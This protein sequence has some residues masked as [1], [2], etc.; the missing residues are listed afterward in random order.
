MLLLLV[1]LWALVPAQAA[2]RLGADAEQCVQWPVPAPL[3]PRQAKAVLASQDLG[4]LT[5]L[6][7]SGDYSRGNTAAR[8]QIAQHFYQSH[9]DHF[10]TLIVFSSFE[11]D[12]GG[13]TAVYHPVRNDVSGIG[14]ESFDFASDYGSAGRLSGIVD[15]AALSRYALN[16]RDRAYTQT[17]GV[18]AHELQH[19]FAAKVRYQPA[20][21]SVSTDL[22]GEGG[23]HW[24]YFLDTDASLMYGSDWQVSPQ[25]FESVQVRH[26]FSPLDL[27]LAGLAAA[28]EVPPLKLI[29][30]GAG[31]AT[32]LP[33][34]GARTTGSQE[35]I[36]IGQIIAAEGPR[37]PDTAVAP[38][39][40][41][42]ALLV[43][44]RPGQT[45]PAEQLLQLEQ[46]RIHIAQFYQAATLGRATL[47]VGNQRSP[48]TSIAAPRYV[49]PVVTDPAAQM[50]GAN[51][52]AV[53]LRTRQ[54][55]DGRFADLPSTALRDT[56]L[57]LRALTFWQPTH[58]GNVLARQW[59]AAQS[60]ASD[61]GRR[62]QSYGLGSDPQVPALWLSAQTEEG[63][64][65]L[66]AGWSTSI[67]DTLIATASLQQLGQADRAQRALLHLAGFQDA[68]GGMGWIEQGVA[69]ESVVARFAD[70]YAQSGLPGTADQLLRSRSWLEA[71][72]RGDG[73]FGSP[74]STLHDSVMVLASAARLG[75]STTRRA[76]LKDFVLLRSSGSL[77]SVQS[78]GMLAMT[79][80]A[81][82]LEQGGNLAIEGP[83][84]VLPA[85]P[86]DGQPV[87]LAVRVRNTGSDPV[88]ASVLRWFE[89]EP[90]AG[91]V[92]FGDDVQVPTLPPGGS[93]R[94]EQV[95]ESRGRPGAHPFWVQLDA[96][97][98]VL[99][100]REDDNLAQV[101]VVVAPAPAG[102][103][104]ALV[105]AETTLD[106][107]RL[108]T[109]PATVR[110]RGILRNLGAT[111]ASQARLELAIVTTAGPSVVASALLD[112]A[113]RGETPFDLSYVSTQ[114][115]PL[116]FSLRVDPDE[117]WTEA[118][119]SNNSVSLRLEFGSTL[120]L[121]IAAADLLLTPAQPA[122]GTLA[123]LRVQLHNRGTQNAQGVRL[124]VDSEVGSTTTTLLD[125]QLS[126]PAAGTASRE[127]PWRP[128][129]A[130]STRLRVRLDPDNSIAE[131]DETN[132]S[133][134][135]VV[136]VLPATGI[137]LFALPGSLQLTPV[138]PLEGQPLA[139][140]A[141][142]R[143]LGADAAP[144]FAVHLYSGT[145]GSGGSLLAQT[146]VPGLAANAE[147]EVQLA[148]ADLP[149][150]GAHVLHLL[151]DATGLVDERD[152]TD[153]LLVQDV[154]VRALPD[155]ALGSG[156][157]RLEPVQP[158]AGQPLTA[159]LRIENLGEQPAT[160]VRA[161]LLLGLPEDGSVV[162]PESVVTSIAA[163]AGVDL[164]WTFTLPDPAPVSVLSAIVD[165][166]GTVRET[167]EDNNRV[168]VSF[169][170]QDGAFFASPVWFS[171]DGDGVQDQTQLV[172]R[173]AS[174]SSHRVEIRDGS[175]RLVRTWSGG[176]G[177]PLVWSWDGRD[178][179]GRVLPDGRYEAQAVA[180]TSTP[181]TAPLG[182]VMVILDTNRSS[183]LAALGTAFA[184]VQPLRGLVPDVPIVEPS[185]LYAVGP[186]TI[187]NGVRVASLT[188]YDVVAGGAPRA[189]IADAL[190][191]QLAL[192]AGLD[193]LELV[194][195]RYARNGSDALLAVEE[196]GSLTAPRASLWSVSRLDVSPPQRLASLPTGSIVLGELAD[197]RIVIGQ[198]DGNGAHLV[199]RSNGS[200]TPYRGFAVPAGQSVRVTDSGLLFFNLQPRLFVPADPVLPE[201]PLAGN[202]E[203]NPFFNGRSSLAGLNPAATHLLQRRRDPVSGEGR[204]E[205]IR[206][207]GGQTQVLAQ[208]PM[209][210]LQASFDVLP[211]FDEYSLDAV[212]L[213]DAQLLVL[214][215]RLMRVLWFG[216]DGVLRAQQDLGGFRREEGYAIPT[217]FG[218]MVDRVFPGGNGLL[219]A[220]RDPWDGLVRLTAGESVFVCAT[221]GGACYQNNASGAEFTHGI[222]DRFVLGIGQ[223]PRAEAGWALLPMAGI[224]DRLRYPAGEAFNF[225]ALAPDQPFRYFD[226]G[227]VLTRS[228]YLIRTE[229]RVT[230][231]DVQ[232]LWG[233]E[234]H[235]RTS[236]NGALSSLANLTALLR[237]QSLGRSI[238]LSGTI[239]DAALAAWELSWRRE[240]STEAWQSIAAPQSEAV[241]DDFLLD[242]VPPGAGSWRIRLTA[243]DRAGNQRVSYAFADTSGAPPAIGDVQLSSRWL[244]PNGDGQGET[245][246][247]RL[248]VDA[249][250]SADV[251]VRSLDSGAIVRR[252][253]PV[254]GAGD[255]GL[256]TL[257][258]DGRSDAG[259]L[260]PDGPYQVE[261]APGFALPLEIDTQAPVGGI[262]WWRPLPLWQPN[263]LHNSG[264]GVF[265]STS[266]RETARRQ[267]DSMPVAGSGDWSESIDVRSDCA[268]K[269]AASRALAHRWRARLTDAA[270]NATTL[271]MP[272]VEA[273]L[274]LHNP[275]RDSRPEVVL[276]GDPL[277][278]LFVDLSP[279][280]SGLRLELAPNNAP[281]QWRFQ[282]RVS[283]ARSELT[284]DA[285]GSW[286]W[287]GH[288]VV[289]PLDLRAEAPG[290]WLRV[291]GV[292]ERSNASELP[293]NAL[294]LQ[295]GVFEPAG[296]EEPEL[297]RC[298]AVLR[299]PI[300][301]RPWRQ[302]QLSIQPVGG[303][304]GTVI[305]PSRFHQDRQRWE[306]DAAVPTGNW[307]LQA[308]LVD[309]DGV[310]RRTVVLETGCS[311][312]AVLAEKVELTAASVRLSDACDAPADYRIQ[313]RV[314][315]TSAS[316]PAS[317]AR[318]Y[319]L[320]LANP[321]T[322]ASETLLDVQ[323]AAHTALPTVERQLNV[324]GWPAGMVRLQ[325]QIGT[326]IVPLQFELP[327]GHAPAPYFQA[328]A[329]GS[330]QCGRAFPAQLGDGNTLTPQL[331]A[332]EW[333]QGAAPSEWVASGAPS[334]GRGA[335]I[336]LTPRGALPH[337]PTSVRF[338]AASQDGA[339]ACAVRLFEIDAQA[340]AVR[341][342][343]A[344][345]ILPATNGKLGLSSAGLEEFRGL[346]VPLL[347]LEPLQWR[348]T[349]APALRQDPLVPTG[350]RT[351]L[352]PVA[353]ADGEYRFS[354]DGRL[355][356]SFVPDGDYVLRI[357]AR[358]DCAHLKNFDHAVV[359][360]STPPQIDLQSPPAGALI[361]SAILE[362]R[363]TVVD[364]N[365]RV[366][367]TEIAALA[368]PDQWT[369]LPPGGSPG[370]LARWV[371]GNASGPHRLRLTA[372][373]PLGN[374]RTLL[375]ELNLAA[376]ARLL[377][378]AEVLP[379]WFSPNGDGVADTTRIEI[380][381]AQSA[382]L[383]LKAMRG[384]TLLRTLDA[385]TDLQP[386]GVR[387]YVWDGR[388]GAGALVADGEVRLQLR[389]TS[390]DGSITEQQELVLAID[391][392]A[393]QLSDRVPA[394]ADLNCAQVVSHSIADPHF[395]RYSG[396]LRAADQRLLREVISEQPGPMVFDTLAAFGDAGTG[397]LHLDVVAEDLA[398]NRLQ[399]A[400]PLRLDCELPT[401]E[402]TAPAVDAVLPRR[403]GDPQP[404]AGRALDAQLE[405]W[406][407]EIGSAPAGDA[408]TLIQQGSTPVDGATL[409][410]WQVNAP[411]GAHWLRLQ[412]RDRA[413]N[414]ASA[415][416]GIQV[417]GTPPVAAIASPPDAAT[418]T[419]AL[420]VTGSASDDHLTRYAL[421]LARSAAGP[422]ADAHVGTTAVQSGLLGELPVPGEGEFFLRLQV[423]D[424]AGFTTV[425]AA[426]R[427]RIDAAPP[428][429]PAT[430]TA[431]AEQNRD[432][433]LGWSEVTVADLAGYRIQRDGQAIGGAL[434]Q[435]TEFL[436]AH[437][438]EGLLSYRVYA[439]DTAGNVGE[440]S[441]LAS[442]AID[443]TPPRVRLLS[444]L[445]DSRERG[446]V[447]V[448]GSVAAD[449][450]LA[451]YSLE[452][453]PLVPPGSAIELRRS[454]LPVIAGELG[455]LDSSGISVETQGV[456]RLL[457]NDRLGN[458]ASASVAVTIDNQ[459]PA[460]PTGLTPTA[461]A[462]DVRLQWNANAETDLLGYLLYRNGVPVNAGGQV[463]GDLRALALRNNEHLDRQVPDGAQSWRV[464]AIDRA[465]NISPPSV[466]VSLTVEHG[467]PH[468]TFVIPASG[469]AF[470][471][472]A[473]FVAVCDDEDVAA[474][475]FAWRPAG[476]T[477]SWNQLATIEAP[478]WRVRWTPTAA[479]PLGEYDVRALA[480]DTGGR[481]DPVPERR[482]V[483][484]ADLTPPPVPEA[485]TALADGA[486]V[487]LSWPAVA[488]ADLA[489]Y[490]LLR[491]APN[492]ALQ[493]LTP[494]P[495]TATT[496]LDSNLLDGRWVY[497]L[498]AVDQRGN[499]SASV[500]DEAQLFS[501]QLE[502]PFTPVAQAHVTLRG[503]SAVAGEVL[504]QRSPAFDAPPA[505]T[506]TAPEGGFEVPVLPL[507]E[508]SNI[509]EVR[510]RSVTGD[511][512]R[513]AV[514]HLDRGDVPP[515]PT[516]L[517][518]QL[519]ADQ[520]LLDWDPAA[521]PNLLGYTVRDRGE[522]IPASAPL[523]SPVTLSGSCCD[524]GA[525]HDGD[526]QTYWYSNY[527]AQSVL[528]W[529]WTQSALV[530]AL[531][532]DWG[533]PELRARS[534]RLSGWS[535]HHWVS[536]LEVT[537]VAEAAGTLLRLPAAYRTDALR[538]ELV[539]MLSYVHVAESQIRV[540]PLLSADSVALPATDGLHRFQVSA[541]NWY[542]MQSPWSTP[543]VELPVGD[544]DPPPA[545]TL[546]GVVE[547]SSARLSWTGA[548]ADVAQWL[549]SRDGEVIAAIASTEAPAHVDG[550][551]RNGRYRYQ[552]EAVDAAGN[553]SAASNTVELDIAATGPAVPRLDSVRPLNTGRALELRWTAGSEGAAVT[554]F[555]I[556]NSTTADG[557]FA[558]RFQAPPETREFVDDEV[559]NGQTR[560]YRLRALDAQGN[561]SAWS[562]VLSGTAGDSIAPAAP[563]LSLPTLA[564]Q[565]L[566]WDVRQVAVCGRAEPG[567]LVQV[568]HNTQ[569]VGD[570]LVAL[571]ADR[572]RVLQTGETTALLLS[573]LA[574]QGN[575]F[576][577]VYD[578][579]NGVRRAE[580]R[581][582]EEPVPAATQALQPAPR[583]P[584]FARRGDLVWG[585]HP[586]TG[587]LLEYVMG[588]GT[589][590]AG[591]PVTGTESLSNIEAL[592]L[593]AAATTAVIAAT[594]SG[595]RGLWLFDRASGQLSLLTAAEPDALLLEQ[596]ALSG[597]ATLLLLPGRD[598]RLRLRALP[599]GIDTL[600][601]A[602]LDPASPV[603]ARLAPDQR[604]V[605]W[606][607]TGD[608]G[609]SELWL[610]RLAAPAAQRLQSFP[611]SPNT[612]LY[613]ADG[614]EVGVFAQDAL[615]RY[616]TS[617]AANAQIGSS[618]LST[619]FRTPLGLEA[620]A[621]ARLLVRL[622]P[623]QSDAISVFDLAGSFCLR[624]VPTIVG[625]NSYTATAS[626]PGEAGAV[627]PA[628]AAAIIDVPGAGLPDLAVTGTDLR[629]SP[630]AAV[631]GDAVLAFVT[632]RNSGQGVANNPT[633]RVRWSSPAGIVQTLPAVLPGSIAAGS[634]ASIGIDL[635]RPTLLGAWRLQ[636]DAD[637]TGL[638][639]EANESNNSASASLAV[640]SNALPALE[641]TLA[642]S[643]LGPGAVLQG[644]V[645]FVAPAAFQGRVRV[646]VRDPA[647][648]L[649]A[650]VLDAHTGA[651]AAAQ[652]W[653][654]AFQWLPQV[655]AG[656]YRVQAQLLSVAGA[657]LDERNLSV[658]L[659]TQRQL[660]LSVRS[661][662]TS[663]AASETANLLLSLHFQS[664]NALL[665]QS[666][667]RLDAR[668][669]SG[670]PAFTYERAL[671]TLT[672]GARLEQTVP[673]ALLSAAPG[674]Y[675]IELTLSAADGF[676]QQASTS[677]MVLPAQPVAGVAGLLRLLPSASL[678]TG[679][680]ATLE[681]TL[682][683]TG[684]A[685][686][687]G[688]TARV[689]LLA[690]PA[691]TEIA[692][693]SQVLS[694]SAQQAQARSL[695]V[696]AAQI[697]VGDYL[698]VLEA[699]L[700]EDPADSWR[701]LAQASLRVVDGMAPRITIER[702]VAASFQ[703]R[704]TPIRATI[705]DDESG[706]DRAE[707]R[708]DSGAW[709]AIGLV[710]E[711][712]YGRTEPGLAEGAHTVEMRAWDRQGNLSQTAILAFEVDAQPPVIAVQG[713]SDGLQ[714]RDPLTPLI[715]V[716]D[717]HLAES[718]ITLDGLA[719]VSGTLVS[720]EG[721]HV[722]SVRASDLAGNSS[723]RTLIF[724]IDRSAP[725]VSFLDPAEGSQHA[726]DTV[727]VS[728]RSEAGARIA[729]QAQ[730]WGGEGL[731]DENGQ[732][733]F[734]AVP[735]LPGANTLQAQATDTA[736]NTGPSATLSLFRLE[737]TAS[738]L[739]DVRAQAAE[740]PLGTALQVAVRIENQGTQPRT[741]TFVLQ[742][743]PPTGSAA[744]YAS[745]F[746]HSFAVNE[747]HQ[748]TLVVPTTGYGLGNHALVLSLQDPA[749]PPQQLGNNAV[750][751]VDAEAPQLSLLSPPA[752]VAAALDIRARAQDALSTLA[753]VRARLDGGAWLSLPAD[754]AAPQEFVLTQVPVS[755][756]P[757]QMD[758]EALDS[759][760]NRASVS[761]T[762]LSDQ[763]AP[764]LTVSGVSDGQLGNQ[765]VTPVFSASD[766]HPGSVQATLDGQSF[767]SGTEVGTD[768]L[769]TLLVT[770]T[771]AV[772]NSSQR[773]LQFTIDRTP[774]GLTI[775]QPADGAVILMP[776]V[777]VTGQTEPL[778]TVLLLRGGDQ[779]T[780][781]ADAAGVFTVPAVNLQPG[782]N[783]LSARAT[784]R[785]GNIGLPRTVQVEY[786]LNAGVTLE[787]TL[788]AN[789]PHPHGT[790]L[791][792]QV[793]VRNTGSQPAQNLPLRLDARRLGQT[794]LLDRHERLQ[795]LAVG[796]SQ[797][798]IHT[799]TSTA[800]WPWAQIEIRLEAQYTL[801]DG[802]QV[803]SP[804]ATTLVQLRDTVAPTL[805][806]LAPVA[807]SWHA[808]TV[809][810]R[811][812]ASDALSG[813][814]QVQARLGEGGP[815]TLKSVGADQYEG[816]LST[817]AVADGVVLLHLSASDLDGNTSTLTPRP[818]QIDRLAP[819][820]QILDVADGQW[821]RD[822]VLPRI[823]VTDVNPTSTE[824]TL[825]GQIYTPG[826]PIN[827]EGAHLLRVRATD[828]AGNTGQTEVRFTIDRTAPSI[829]L[830]HPL[831]GA[832]LL[833]TQVQLIGST[834]A[835]AR[836]SASVLGI[837]QQTLADAQG[838]FSFNVQL[839]RGPN[840]I[841][842]TAADALGNTSAPLQLTVLVIADPVIA[843]AGAIDN[844]PATLAHGQ[845]LDFQTRVRNIGN[846]HLTAVPLFLRVQTVTAPV[847]EIGQQSWLL[848]LEVNAQSQRAQHFKTAAWPV[849]QLRLIL[850]AELSDAGRSS[851][852]TRRTVLASQDLLLEDRTAPTLAWLVPGAIGQALRR[853]QAIE[854]SASD[855]QSGLDVVEV[856]FDQGALWL[857]MAPAEPKLGR[858]I[859]ALGDLA[860]GTHQVE[861]RARDR[862]GNTE[863]LPVR[864]FNL[865]RVLPL[866]LLEPA[867]GATTAAALLDLHALS[868]PLARV[869]L[870]RQ[871]QLLREV[872]A[873]ASGRVVLA[874]VPLA[875]G[876]NSF[877]V[878]AFASDGAS[879]AA[880]EWRIVRR[881]PPQVPVAVLAPGGRL[882][883]L[884]LIA[885]IG[886]GSGLTALRRAGGAP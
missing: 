483:R 461:V 714:T 199:D 296:L 258:F 6:E 692:V 722:L 191:A 163:G 532:L 189:R 635:G 678:G 624:Q 798:F 360:D 882:L 620:A 622:D 248:R 211:A 740:V 123:Q 87:T 397:E 545:P 592:R 529:R 201:V 220:T 365:G 527:D 842:L 772:G 872:V 525:A 372:S 847:Q 551:L 717:A 270:G 870:R 477:Q 506:S 549:L 164:S 507:A 370:V 8:Q 298:T 875:F 73:G 351:A 118:D 800:S 565:S 674:G 778:A 80:Q 238:R 396:Q 444:P 223:A 490:E 464:Y 552:L 367:K 332:L 616:T 831:P 583:Q 618:D 162:P 36:D 79:L 792:I 817:A 119:E 687:T 748:R 715:S 165:P 824:A 526:P 634:S 836:L 58:P 675:T 252:F 378:G 175:G 23:V 158:I 628:S 788:G 857:P 626:D 302:V 640:T 535:G 422:W 39:A 484:Y 501:V 255:L 850:E 561:A 71:R 488:A 451:Q 883:L 467:P 403:A 441:P 773:S 429:A 830:I 331:F 374:E 617:G 524:P 129:A 730:G 631:S 655:S 325:A 317:V 59:L 854:V 102:V 90:G 886:I 11:F 3:P 868:E 637:P 837:T 479:I 415:I 563:V 681:W 590:L 345:S 337:G 664:G 867:P 29:R 124:L 293:S 276:P 474:V 880:L 747:V 860:A 649:V 466:T 65:G 648:V 2:P 142:L 846:T 101:E 732:V 693:D 496:Y 449:D 52:L 265:V 83:V 680:A 804:V 594:R 511:R 452:F 487:R 608:A 203:T 711:G 751:L 149:L 542:G 338:R 202:Q 208:G 762:V 839:A 808:Q 603:A 858:W 660:S 577:A 159:H 629:F 10:D 408:W 770:A 766:P 596:L 540:Q 818:L 743:L 784:D 55:G 193:R 446:E 813:L 654:S 815:V 627:S 427:L 724:H 852:G 130:G 297:G 690:S 382:R 437:A 781:Q 392:V 504:L 723:Q 363:G 394:S 697:S 63:G 790:P 226:S 94:T 210:R 243:R 91:G 364:A 145:P 465:G 782:A 4:N 38:R 285:L 354:W 644:H 86:Y 672:P 194:Q 469:H 652:P 642:T 758:V 330:R 656:S 877:R 825:D 404:I 383:D 389:L 263:C 377:G 471:Q 334:T 677:L 734:P 514:L 423:E 107:N 157:L 419:S 424:G 410:T 310:Q 5:V 476:S 786:R 579:P 731:A 564:T 43:L 16:P 803:W 794:A 662:R 721:S 684:T 272:P 689:R 292:G 820:V 807:G 708:I 745:E 430:L 738:W 531:Q 495:L 362:L 712:R 602:T 478:P 267:L 137:N 264:P 21:G 557:P 301:P 753:S 205:L 739:G 805:A 327:P 7:F 559:A 767:V 720:A 282:S 657:T 139:V 242:W 569:P 283:G 399:Q 517:Q 641:L 775:Q 710:G 120:D 643:V 838:E 473:E 523:D 60:P 481:V 425:T 530:T 300:L 340:D 161:R 610:R 393:P 536:L 356:G 89:G 74:Q 284:E 595:E 195:L 647:G 126:L 144:P 560:W 806:L 707:L 709:T 381:V 500:E 865:L 313:L 136:D 539:S 448:L 156:A 217:S 290:S 809:L 456:F 567:S 671:G 24:S 46:L 814:Q 117:R 277:E 341:R 796:A 18:L 66:R 812:S 222:S 388:D 665:N 768:G 241:I 787:A 606:L 78:V 266:P 48:S 863:A 881:G 231:G 492:G 699:R 771:D 262:D 287:L 458:S 843:L 848:D 435:G 510:V 190:W 598:G 582:L 601:T 519:A 547:G 520:M 187:A 416:R 873:D 503:R 645:R 268:F 122:A 615:L 112:V 97:G 663:Y 278:R 51:A 460:A 556:Q 311:E 148:V 368:T 696:P 783:T 180:L 874:Q 247:L 402:L 588:A 105:A 704:P 700:P 166:A 320:R 611:T 371:R 625:R 197:G 462:L 26:R 151:V 407:L 216:A 150:R 335:S 755:E 111:P 261:V 604:S 515:A 350:P 342:D 630:G 521:I 668:S 822:P 869:T 81:L 597:D 533:A 295:I 358:D 401:A 253:L 727:P 355:G 726:T 17:L 581:S 75:L 447:I 666:R 305:D 516:G 306:F 135:I 114:A 57:A 387:A 614:Q 64:Y 31:Q 224:G 68:Q 702:P 115:V 502:V 19:R 230:Q 127:I 802:S 233:G 279:G 827:A 15:M 237:A 206:L 659:L 27:Y 633:L 667:L 459:A 225:D 841:V 776:S 670:T 719:F 811:A 658:Q 409:A 482:S 178:S 104:L 398:G 801:P 508:G 763:S 757:H 538:L 54:Q 196:A 344:S 512:S 361:D 41:Q 550:G 513:A 153:N 568:L 698:G 324:N 571:A 688:V 188:E 294:T 828:L 141:R 321:L 346:S 742:V 691:L 182:P 213:D 152:E 605:S 333:G 343:G 440:G 319:Q 67:A 9:P 138:Q 632:V 876:D 728:L 541:W 623:F 169:S 505:G 260:L 192:A 450:D 433:R 543:V 468:A 749:G 28:S 746:T 82:A 329:A 214:D 49:I 412:V 580:L 366:L 326:A 352:G 823:V 369:T 791:P 718:S 405:Q 376:P 834:E 486:E 575:S 239:S 128:T 184:R 308:S 20:G 844:A 780:V 470:E 209:V 574:P 92:G 453:Q 835:A 673:W 607:Q 53:V 789:T 312:P 218:R 386:A 713:V 271:V 418:V 421:Q 98:Q 879:S 170:S 765:A 428:P 587:E 385:G 33:R 143:N 432:V 212:W 741:G 438:P 171:P 379:A 518:A 37:Q 845:A 400:L 116:D 132:N 475:E 733:R 22:L 706:V 42:A 856:R 756:G 280:L 121:A 375:R 318:R 229:G 600:L 754:P 322:Q 140:S 172:F 851:S 34:L 61:D 576:L 106:P 12:T 131:L 821:G 69:Q 234:R 236:N 682:R 584:V 445:P 13:A 380:E 336:T 609:S 528:E 269:V 534:L 737:S 328:P 125:T 299:A 246:D 146:T 686:V 562:N 494:T 546:S 339:V 651:V 155:L 273:A 249:P 703:P 14:I 85:Q 183:V 454:G 885:V 436:D 70:A 177:P 853:D 685:P 669:A 219:V 679:Q 291:R 443:R 744:V 570:P 499:R 761:A 133:A 349:L 96:A 47:R 84:E 646:Q 779:Y 558:L 174:G 431:S 288:A 303:G 797:S 799:Y 498:S 167:R 716:T 463:P 589:V 176:Q 554:A 25:G 548:T 819:Q 254:Y 109:V 160:A 357:E 593:D 639:V 864:T 232:D 862:A 866:E 793:Q 103:E 315:P 785:A 1:G 871:E 44:V 840:T 578:D 612:L 281:N 406:R 701:R 198:P 72:Q 348:A 227:A 566:R 173:A 56:A 45:V 826:T 769:H 493:S 373:D 99:E 347:G 390:A 705:F 795:S 289:A 391:T 621:P 585:V 251:L 417:D 480:R 725:G 638:L 544:I 636:V 215:S 760:G 245:V 829:T 186:L 413:G 30:G 113:A 353:L 179:L 859:R 832:T 32:D 729:L 244:S 586:D 286:Q 200:V 185:L 147:H 457:A 95:W 228:G 509:V 759:Q 650:T 736:G 777:G 491:I 77:D 537:E 240:G 304:S 553:R 76:L 485:L 774:P 134:D 250:V 764:L 442:A 861:V 100:S 93:A 849:G 816:A 573:V 221:P 359:V 750:Q 555:E 207:L 522:V 414:L 395:L 316:V 472:S 88:A 653:T 420:Q 434:V 235:A 572:R 439:V 683:N 384:S 833:A 855:A 35:S 50:A 411:D 695:I 676:Q 309:G 619:F 314:A 62:W 752:L 661:D 256:R 426:R 257:S 591:Q 735:L 884:L 455:R 259:Q 154:L 274:S 497:R 275:A 204:I 694:L 489:G 810:L 307:R 181:P 110:V 108:D 168:S 613:L 599:A 323:V 40:F 878:Q